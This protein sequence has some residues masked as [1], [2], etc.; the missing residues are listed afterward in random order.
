MGL[1]GIGLA[2]LLGTSVRLAAAAGV[3][4]MGFPLFAEYRWRS[5]IA[6]VP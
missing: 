5:M 2:L 6:P 1:L 4:V 3:V